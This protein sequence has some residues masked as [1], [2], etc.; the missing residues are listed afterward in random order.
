MDLILNNLSS[1]YFNLIE[2]GFWVILGF[3]C[4]AIYF[5]IKSSYKTL[6]LFS[7]FVLVTFGI[8]DFFQVAYGSFLV[9][10]M[11]WLFVW[12]IVDVIGLC[13]IC[14]WYLILRIRS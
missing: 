8:S 11:E 13:I 4:L 10:G 1:E 12:K 14:L 9:S 2:G 3:V 6:V 5:K 7:S